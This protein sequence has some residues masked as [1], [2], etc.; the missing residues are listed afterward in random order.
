MQGQRQRFGVIIPSTNT[1]VE[2]DF[3]MIRPDDVTFHYG[4][5]YLPRPNLGSDE[6]FLDLSTRSGPPSAP[7]CGTS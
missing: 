2:H 4:R 5:M 3:T 6:D 7:P 1:V